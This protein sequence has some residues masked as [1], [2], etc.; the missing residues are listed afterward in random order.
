MSAG[1]QRIRIDTRHLPTGVYAYRLVVDGVS[2]LGR[3]V[4]VR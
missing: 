2:S 1:E 3:I 4:V